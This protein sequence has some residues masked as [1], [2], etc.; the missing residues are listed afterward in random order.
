MV[1]RV[2]TSQNQQSLMLISQKKR[3]EEKPVEFEEY[4]EGYDRFWMMKESITPKHIE[5]MVQLIDERA[6]KK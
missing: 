4:K 3:N 2:A 6:G 1:P 5:I